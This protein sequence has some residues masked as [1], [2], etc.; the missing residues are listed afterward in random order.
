MMI[1]ST[2]SEAIVICEDDVHELREQKN[3]RIKSMR[4][5]NDAKLKGGKHRRRSLAGRRRGVFINQERKYGDR[6]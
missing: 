6:R 2:L 5:R 4:E 3:T 1:K